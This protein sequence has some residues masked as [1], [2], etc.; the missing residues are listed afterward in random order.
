M[1]FLKKIFEKIIGKNPQK[2]TPYPLFTQT[3]EFQRLVKARRF[4]AKLRLF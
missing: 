1:A 4:Q 2:E 3:K